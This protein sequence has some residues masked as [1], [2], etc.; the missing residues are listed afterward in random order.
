ADGK[1]LFF[2]ALTG[3]A[4]SGVL[5]ADIALGPQPQAGTPRMLFRPTGVSSPAQLSNIAT[6]DGARF[7]FLPQVPAPAR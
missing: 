3:L 4:P 6:G 5:A 7:V 2:I 1:E